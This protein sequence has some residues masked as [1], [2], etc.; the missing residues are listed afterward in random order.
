VGGGIEFDWDVGNIRHLKRHSVMPGEFEELMTVDPVY[1]EYQSSN[2][3]DEERYKI[4]GLT[5]AGRILIGVWTPRNGKVRAITAYDAS[6]P[7]RDLY[8][9]M[10]R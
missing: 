9:E 6:R 10:H 3:D 7:Y 5:R 4:L 2:D 1:L 8:Q